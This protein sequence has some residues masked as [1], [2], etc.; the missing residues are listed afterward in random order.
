MSQV[1]ELSMVQ[2]A[3]SSVVVAGEEI[4]WPWRQSLARVPEAPPRR[5]GADGLAGDR[6]RRKWRWEGADT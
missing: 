3:G 5:A 6:S 2:R 1:G 4:G